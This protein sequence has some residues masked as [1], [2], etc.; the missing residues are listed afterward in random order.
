MTNEY[1]STWNILVNTVRKWSPKLKKPDGKDSNAVL[2]GG[3]GRP[4]G[5]KDKASTKRWERCQG[6]KENLAEFVACCAWL[7]KVTKFTFFAYAGSES[8]LIKIPCE[9]DRLLSVNFTF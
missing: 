1:T 5:A 8:V 4:T 3:R 2:R 9:Q 6:Y 7:L